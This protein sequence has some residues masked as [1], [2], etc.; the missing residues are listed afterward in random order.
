MAIKTG[1]ELDSGTCA[2]GENTHVHL[3]YADHQGWVSLRI[4]GHTNWVEVDRLLREAYR[5]VALKRM[6]KALEPQG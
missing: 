5:Q 6:L 1:M 4:D 3:A 2:I